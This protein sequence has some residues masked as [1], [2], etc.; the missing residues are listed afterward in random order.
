MYI[1]FLNDGN[2]NVIKAERKPLDKVSID[3]EDMLKLMALILLHMAAIVHKSIVVEM[4]G[5]AV[6]CLASPL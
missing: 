6:M 1:S 3:Y 2:S 4:A 5:S